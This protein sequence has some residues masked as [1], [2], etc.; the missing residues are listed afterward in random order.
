MELEDYIERSGI[1]YWIY[2]HSHYNKD[3]RIGNTMC[4]S[5]QLGYAFHQEHKTFV[6][7]KCIV[8]D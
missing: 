2:G 1:D 4:L 5:N 8:L 3:V 7:D 6:P